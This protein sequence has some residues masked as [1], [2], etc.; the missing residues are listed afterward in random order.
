MIG[1]SSYNLPWSGAF[2]TRHPFAKGHYDPFCQISE[3]LRA[4]N[5]PTTLESDQFMEKPEGNS[6]KGLEHYRTYLGL[7]A[8]EQFDARLRTKI[9]PSD[10]VQQTLAEA[11]E[12][13]DQF[14]GQS[15]AQ[16]AGWL[17]K[18][19]ANNLA[20]AHRRFGAAKRDIAQERALDAALEHIV[21]QTWRHSGKSGLVPKPESDTARGRPA[22]REC[23]GTTARRPT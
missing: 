21:C 3:R 1:I 17:R 15:S 10:I 22:T 11:F 20:D 8:R 18:I 19:L 6:E 14:R 9:D 2:D 16:K 7:L 13:E 23:P 12:H 4:L 5:S